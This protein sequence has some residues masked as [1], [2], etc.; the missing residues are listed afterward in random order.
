VHPIHAPVRG[1]RDFFIHI[2]TTSEELNEL[3]HPPDLPTNE[4]LCAARA[5]TME[6]MKA[7]GYV[8]SNPPPAQK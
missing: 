5:L 7:A 2:A 3:R 4:L 1:W 8:Y 6:R